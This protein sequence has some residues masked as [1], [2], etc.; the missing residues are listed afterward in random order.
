M[1]TLLKQKLFPANTF[2]EPSLRLR[3]LV[4]AAM[5]IPLLALV[6]VAPLGLP[7]LL[8]AVGIGLGHWYSYRYRNGGGRL[9]RWFIFAAIHLALLW[10]CVG[11]VAGATLPQA[12]FA[13]FTQ[14]ITS[15]DLRYRRSLFNTLF[16]SLANLYIAASLS[17]TAELGLYLIL[18]AGLVLAV[19]YTAEA[20]DAAK[21]ARL[22]PTSALAGQTRHRWRLFWFG[23]SFGLAA[24]LAL[25]VAFLF[26]PRFAGR[27]I[28]PPFSINIPLRGGIK[29]QVINPGLPLVQV[30]GWSN[31]TGDYFYGFDSTLDL[32]YRGGLSDE[33]VMYVRSPSRSYWRSHSFDFYTGDSWQ[34]SD[35]SLTPLPRRQGVYFQIDPP[36]GSPVLAVAAPS[37]AEQQIVQSFTIVR[38][39]PNLI[40]AAYRP[41]ELYIVAETASIDSGDAIRLPDTLKPGM[42]YSV[43]SYRPDFDPDKLRQ[44]GTT[45]PP[46]IVPRYRQLPANISERV[47]Q[48]A[49]NLTAP[50]ANNYDKVMALTNHLLTTYPY[51]F[52]PPPHPP[53]AEVVDTFLFEDKE[54]VCEQYA[55]ALVVMARSLG[56]PARLVTGYGSGDYN[57]LTGYYEVRLNHAHS[58]AEVYFP[59]YGWVP[60]DPTPGW[61]P[62]PYPTPVQTWIFSGAEFLGIELPVADLVSGGVAGVVAVA[63]FLG[64]MALVGGW[65]VL[66]YYLW[67]WL[68]PRWGRSSGQSYSLM[69]PNQTRLMILK[70]YEQG[71]RL[72]ARRKFRKREAWET[73]DE[74]AASLSRFPALARLTHAVEIAAYRPEAPDTSTLAEAR[75]AFNGLRDEASI[76]PVNRPAKEVDN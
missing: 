22:K 12:Q 33:I 16:I 48:L 18:F 44:A 68:K 13:I 35:P 67:R 37:S 10:L 39:Q 69:P 4:L 62:Q 25:C 31:D 46:E 57:P 47:K 52:F 74:Y 63:P 75:A 76:K 45:Y 51:N 27:P 9:V 17:R 23:L 8:A 21:A 30:N 73:L 70:L 49:L 11:L 55:T 64:L 61:T 59:A 72:L 42:T 54:G 1:L 7:V 3:G 66:F 24:L 56:I 5:L 14:A 41:A 38:E 6:R 20:E 2:P 50:H 60:F 58:W 40:F 19:F 43:V 71:I 32:R 26:T 29:A 36:L 15:F 65:L 34:Q 53:G 28:V